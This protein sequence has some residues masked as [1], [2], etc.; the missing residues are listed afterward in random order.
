[1]APSP[2]LSTIDGAAAGETR[3]FTVGGFAG[4]VA[5]ALFAVTLVLDRVVGDPPSEGVQLLAWATSHRVALAFTNESLGFAAALLIPFVL[6]LYRRMEGPDRPW[7]AFGCGLLAVAVPV[8]LVLVIVHGRLMYP[9]FGIALDDGATV[10]LVVSLYE[11]GLHL[12]WL[13]V[14]AALIIVALAMR[15][16]AWG[17][18]AVGFGI[19]VGLLQIAG[20][21]PSL[22]GPV[23][24][25]ITRAAFVAWLVF[26]GVR[27]VR[28][29]PDPP[30][31]DSIV[32]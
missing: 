6:A 13:M 21:Y 2:E 5:G 22:L 1:M 30:R 14:G 4:A 7:A 23:L 31:R 16:G 28:V 29:Q 8:L 27:L 10:A 3:R 15:R 32:G 11:G 20:G 9:V 18:G 19:V 26:V 25:A 17:R 24:T 12:V